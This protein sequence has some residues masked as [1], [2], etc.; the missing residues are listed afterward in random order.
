MYGGGSVVHGPILQ[1]ARIQCRPWFI[2]LSC[3]SV[4][5]LLG[6]PLQPRWGLLPLLA[7]WGLD[8]RPSVSQGV[9]CCCSSLC[10]ARVV[11]P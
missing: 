3:S 8:A 6:C 9:L 1:L 10:M 2:L 5:F 4:S 11:L 7:E